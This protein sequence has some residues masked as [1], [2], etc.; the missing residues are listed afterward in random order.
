[1]NITQEEKEKLGRALYALWGEWRARQPGAAERIVK[2]W[3]SLS[4]EDR[5]LLS[6]L[7]M[8]AALHIKDKSERAVREWASDHEILLRLVLSFL[9]ALGRP[10]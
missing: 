7:G 3:E 4:E 8:Q 1:M 2:G 10:S 5:D 9:S 6:H